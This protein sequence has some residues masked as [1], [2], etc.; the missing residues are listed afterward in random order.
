MNKLE[1]DARTDETG[2]LQLRLPGPPAEYRV[3]VTLEWE[4]PECKR[5]SAWPEGWLEET[6]GSIDDPTFVRPSQGSPE[7]REDMD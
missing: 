6:A 5:P 2:R 4:D 3:R 1:L 7:R